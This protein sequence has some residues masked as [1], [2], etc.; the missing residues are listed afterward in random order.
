MKCI[1]CGKEFNN[2]I[3][4][5]LSV[6]FYSFCT[7]HKSDEILLEDDKFKEFIKKYPDKLLGYNA[8]KNNISKDKLLL[9]KKSIDIEI[10]NNSKLKVKNNK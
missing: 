3:V 6:M 8:W 10:E 1:E 7:E 2:P 5:S 9:K 4:E